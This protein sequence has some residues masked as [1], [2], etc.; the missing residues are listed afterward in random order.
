M[1]DE[2]AAID[3]ARLRRAYQIVNGTAGPMSYNEM[4]E[5]ADLVYRDAQWREVPLR[6]A[7]MA[8]ALVEDYIAKR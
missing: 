1:D 6:E 5:A 4:R 2:K 8:A 7:I 3:D